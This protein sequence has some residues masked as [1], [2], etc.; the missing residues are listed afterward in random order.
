MVNK[1]LGNLL[2]CFVGDKPTS[3]DMVLA[4]AKF[5]YKISSNEP[6]LHLQLQK[7]DVF[8]SYQHSPYTND[9]SIPNLVSLPYAKNSYT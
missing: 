6:L 5:E 4:Q 2:R 3:W 8:S 7:F 9:Y 1:S